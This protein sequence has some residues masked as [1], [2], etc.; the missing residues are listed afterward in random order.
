MRMLREMAEAK[1]LQ[2]PVLV[3]PMKDA[4]CERCLVSFERISGERFCGSCLVVIS[5]AVDLR[6]ARW[7]QDADAMAEIVRQDAGFPCAEEAGETIEC[8]ER[9][10]ALRDCVSDIESAMR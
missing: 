10:R 2:S 6:L 3:V 1:T 4:T 8:K 5:S 7:K 9:E